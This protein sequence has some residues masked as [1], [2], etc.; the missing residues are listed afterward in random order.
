MNAIIP[1]AT[2]EQMVAHRDR[3]IGLYRV[4]FE[5][6]AEAAKAMKAANDAT[7]PF[8]ANGYYYDSRIHEIE[9]FHKAVRLPDAERFA[10]VAERLTDIQFWTWV[11]EHGDLERLMDKEAKDSLRQQ[12]RYVPLRSRNGRDVIDEEEAAKSFPPVT[13]DNVVATIQSFA[14]Q[15]DFIFKRGVANVFSKLDRRFKS[16]DG[17]K[18]GSRIIMSYFMCSRWGSIRSDATETLMDIERAFAVLDAW[19]EATGEFRHGVNMSFRSVSD[20][21]DR[22]RPRGLGA[23]AFEVR[24]EYFLI[25]VYKNGNA[26]LWMQNDDLVRKVNKVLAEYYGEVIADGAN[27]G[28]GQED[29]FSRRKTT[30]AKAF[31]FFPTP[32]DAVRAFFA[33]CGSY[34]SGINVLRPADKPRLR[35]LEPSA[36]T[37]NLARRCIKTAAE[38]DEWSGG[39]ERH[40]KNYRFDN[41]VVCVEIQ[42]HMADAL[43]A[44]GIYSRVVCADFLSIDPKM[45]GEFDL[46]V[47]NPPF[48]LERD[49]DHVTHAFKFLKPGGTLHAIMSAGTE[50]RETKKAVAFRELVNKCGG[51]M[52]DMPAGSFAES[53]TYVNTIAVKLQKPSA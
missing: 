29:I 39:R 7:K 8:D 49:I 14:A 44:E 5:K 27:D 16:H 31:G 40:E 41:E 18:I 11:I 38:L 3:A 15:A 33:G 37:G 30:P 48:D 32:P 17:F 53:G 13:V 4:A 20:A 47:M 51:R 22:A 52:D 2:I 42:R 23:H 24:T 26:H 45:Y 6:I 12:L 46:V 19:D 43:E 35:I 36:G 28:Q 21:I 10:H 34:G 25:R 50:F 1:R 9:E